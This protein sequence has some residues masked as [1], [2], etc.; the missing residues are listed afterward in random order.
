MLSL[1]HF[2]SNRSRLYNALRFPV[3]AHY[4]S[5]SEKDGYAYSLASYS[6]QHFLKLLSKAPEHRRKILLPD[7][8]CNTLID[9]ILSA[10]AEPIFYGINLESDFKAFSAKEESLL[11]LLDEDVYAVILVD[12]FGVPCHVSENFSENVRNQGVLLIRDASHAY[13]TLVNQEFSG[14]EAFDYTIT[15]LY[16]SLP[17]NIG[18]LCFSRKSLEKSYVSFFKFVWQCVRSCLIECVVSLYNPLIRRNI[19]KLR[20]L[21]F[22]KIEAESGLLKRLFA[23]VFKVF[24]RMID[25]EKI[26]RERKDNAIQIYEHLESY[27]G[28]LIGNLYS[29]E[30]VEKSVFMAY[31]VKCITTKIRD[32]LCD[33]FHEQGV[34]VYTWPVFSECNQKAEV[35]ERILLIPVSRNTLPYL[36]SAMTKV[37]IRKGILEEIESM[38][39]G[40][41]VFESEKII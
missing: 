30:Q 2:K 35:W 9:A 4:E 17:T 6:R 3:K 36:K 13:L 16:K 40:E 33:L 41:T 5:F 24:L 32:D 19:T 34:D 22:Q 10:G 27:S 38:V 15:S 8:M 37:S 14:M 20:S 29:R 31:P 26:I 7:Y 28:N 21:P 11:K 39:D 1:K 23:G 18:S 25:E 12:Y